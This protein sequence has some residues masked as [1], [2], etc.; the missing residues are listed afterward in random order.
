MIISDPD[1]A[2]PVP[3]SWHL[4]ACYGKPG[5]QLLYVHIPKNAS[6]ST[7]ER[8]TDVGFESLNYHD[9]QKYT[10]PVVTVLR[11]PIKRWISGALEYLTLHYPD[12]IEYVND[13]SV[14]FDQFEL[15]E[16]TARQTK[17]LHE[18]DTKNITFLRYNK[19]FENSLVHFFNKQNI[20]LNLELG[21]THASIDSP[22]KQKLKLLL[23]EKINQTKLVEYL[24]PDYNLIE[25]VKFYDPRKSRTT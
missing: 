9:T 18:L 24:Q 4:G 19:R 23:L 11:D 2:M 15:D 7:R 13:T 6:S 3:F 17:F 20:Q 12:P 22:L 5:D 10:N 14:V 8:L 21:W 25:S 16:H 1:F